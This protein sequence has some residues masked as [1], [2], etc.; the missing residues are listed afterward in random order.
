MFNIKDLYEHTQSALTWHHSYTFIV[1]GEAK[2]PPSSCSLPYFP[3]PAA[4]RWLLLDLMFM[5]STSLFL[6]EQ[7]TWKLFYSVERGHV[8]PATLRYLQSFVQLCPSPPSLVQHARP[9][10][11]VDFSF[12]LTLLSSS[13]SLPWWS[14]GGHV[15]WWSPHSQDWINECNNSVDIPRWL[16]GSMWCFASKNVHIFPLKSVISWVAKSW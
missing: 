10:E 5:T 3:F 6:Y 9:L 12:I 1:M 14:R 13:T 2:V 4:T 7:F 11:P 8:G 16:S 15:S